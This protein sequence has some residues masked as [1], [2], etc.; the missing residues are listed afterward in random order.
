MWGNNMK[1]HF[2]AFIYLLIA[3]ILTVVSI[4]ENSTLDIAVHDTYYVIHNSHWLLMLCVYF[5]ILSLITFGLKYFKKWQN[6]IWLHL[7]IWSSLILFCGIIFT[8]NQSTMDTNPKKYYDYSVYDD[9]KNS[10]TNVDYNELLAVL[11]ILFL[12]VQS[13]FIISILVGFI[14]QRKHGKSNA[15]HLE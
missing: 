9:F 13:F 6:R 12:F 5:L 11:L 7:R 4:V 10:S 2:F 15:K 3:F 14:Q 1:K 8:F